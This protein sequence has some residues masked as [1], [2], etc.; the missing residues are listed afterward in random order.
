MKQP[1]PALTVRAPQAR[2]STAAAGRSPAKAA[3]FTHVFGSEGPEVP[4]TMRT[5]GSAAREQ[6]EGW[7]R[8]AHP[9]AKKMVTRW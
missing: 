2:G 5:G 6:T 7:A 1:S 4:R 8:F 9:S 3:F